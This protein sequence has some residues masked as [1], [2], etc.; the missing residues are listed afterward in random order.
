LPQAAQAMLA[1]DIPYLEVDGRI[2]GREFD[3]RDVLADGGY[4]F[5]IRVRGGIGGFDLFEE[6]GFA[7]VVEAEEED[8]VFWLR[9]SYGSVGG[10]MRMWGCGPSL[11]VAWRYMDLKRWYIV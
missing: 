4:G 5:E 3:G 2:R 7:G 1:A 9:V 10:W 8:R 6:G 11:L